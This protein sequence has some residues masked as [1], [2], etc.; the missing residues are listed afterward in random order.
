MKPILVV[1]PNPSIDTYAWID[2]F[3]NGVPNRIKREDRYPGGK[4]LHVAMALAELVI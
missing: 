3:A 1:C 4:G 2:G